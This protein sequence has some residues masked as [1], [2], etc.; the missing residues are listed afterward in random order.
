M[1]FLK[2]NVQSLPIYI[3][4]KFRRKPHSFP[5]GVTYLS[6]FYQVIYIYYYI[7]NKYITILNGLQY[8]VPPFYG[9]WS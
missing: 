1:L 3:Y 7:R 5:R 2:L 8:I 4:L 9:F 6:K